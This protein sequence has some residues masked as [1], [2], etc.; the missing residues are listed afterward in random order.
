MVG[1]SD[2]T[3]LDCFHRQVDGK[4]LREDYY[5]MSFLRH[6]AIFVIYLASPAIFSPHQP[7]T[8]R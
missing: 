3:P 7:A 1:L 8:A 6:Q 4:E 2:R 5:R